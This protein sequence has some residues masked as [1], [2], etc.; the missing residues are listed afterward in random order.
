MNSTN[1]FTGITAYVLY[2][3]DGESPIPKS[4][5]LC[6]T[7]DECDRMVETLAEQYCI[8]E[9]GIKHFIK[10]QLQKSSTHI[11]EGFVLTKVGSEIRVSKRIPRYTIGYS[12]YTICQFGFMPLEITC[13]SKRQINDIFASEAKDEA[14]SITPEFTPTSPRKRRDQSS[15]QKKEL[16]LAEK[17]Q[18]EL[19]TA[20]KRYS[21]SKAVKPKEEPKVVEPKTEAKEEI[22]VKSEETVKECAIQV[23]LNKVKLHNPR[24]EDNEA[25]Q[26][27]DVIECSTMQSLKLPTNVVNINI[28]ENS[29]IDVS[30][31]ELEAL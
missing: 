18:N 27:W 29:V 24:V 11:S 5:G 23:M 19:E 30:V 28:I 12:S 22:Q 3:R 17:H 25:E 16:T 14:T 21:V 15:P 26:D 1:T 13:E 6:Y 20:I 2:R 9:V 4:L 31:P 10:G 8:D 7:P